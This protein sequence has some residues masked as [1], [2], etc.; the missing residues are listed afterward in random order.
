M[1]RIRLIRTVDVPGRSGPWNG[2]YALQRALRAAAWPW[3]ALGGLP[4]A[5]EIPWFWCWLDRRE[6]ARWAGQGRP[7]IAGPNILFDRSWL[8]GAGPGEREILASE[9]CRLLFTESAWYRELIAAHRGP[10]NRAPIVIWPY[11][12]EPRP[13]GPLADRYPLLVYLKSRRLESLAAR[14]LGWFPGSRLVVYGAYERSDLWETARRARACAYL[15]DDDRGPLALAEILLAG[16]PCVGVPRGAPFVEPGFSGVVLPEWDA[17]GALAGVHRC[18]EMDR[19]AVAR[20]AAARFDTASILATLHAALAPLALDTS[21]K[22][23]RFPGK[24]T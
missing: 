8:P 6:A 21:S 24:R 5:G 1:P 13:G 7:L 10:D 4:S 15:S 19:D 9:S 16:C 18:L 20:H 22:A 3:L 23:G 17:I 12:I 14:L 2:Q 11:P